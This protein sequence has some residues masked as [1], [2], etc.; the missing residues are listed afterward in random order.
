MVNIENYKKQ[1]HTHIISKAFHPYLRRFLN[2]PVIEEKK[3]LLLI[4]ILNDIDITEEERDQSITATM[5]LQTALN[6]H[7]DVSETEAFE[8]QE[9]LKSRQL[10]VLAGDYYS[11]MYYYILAQLK[12]IKLI[13]SLA[14]GIKAINEEKIALYQNQYADKKAILDS[15]KVI[16][17][18]LII[19]VEDCFGSTHYRDFI[20]N[21]LLL[22][23]LQIENGLYGKSEKS[24]VYQAFAYTLFS[25]DL[26]QLSKDE[27]KQ[28]VISIENST[29]TVYLA[30]IDALKKMSS[31]NNNLLSFFKT[32][33]MEDKLRVN[34]FV[35]EG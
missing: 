4:F 6:I 11:G 29:K 26:T 7:D 35:E 20:E 28:L 16:E 21:Y 25:K 14:E 8:D 30:C 23:R 1:L 24:S 19:K 31:I 32:T 27:T 3:L 34:S 9:V 17:S 10:T 2:E 33:L 12:N 5:L 15:I 22:H 18:S 13:R